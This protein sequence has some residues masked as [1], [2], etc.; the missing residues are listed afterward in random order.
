MFS[1]DTDCTYEFSLGHE[2]LNRGSGPP[3]V[4]SSLVVLRTFSLVPFGFGVNPTGN[5]I[6]KLLRNYP[7]T[8]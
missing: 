4:M 7:H 6:S 8:D 2:G 5:M 1:V 3:Q